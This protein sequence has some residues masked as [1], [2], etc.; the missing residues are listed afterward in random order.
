MIFN[1]R[2]VG[3]SKHKMC[4]KL[5]DFTQKLKNYLY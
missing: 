2:G 3:V 5:K 1:Y 4:N